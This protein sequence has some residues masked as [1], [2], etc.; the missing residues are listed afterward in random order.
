MLNNNIPTASEDEQSTN[1]ERI[2]EF[3]EDT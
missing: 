3:N 1:L 2:S